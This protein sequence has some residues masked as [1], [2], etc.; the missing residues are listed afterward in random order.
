[1]AI[2]IT[3]KHWR[4]IYTV[5][6]LGMYSLTPLTTYAVTA[7][8]LRGKRYCEIAI[9]EEGLTFA[10]YN[11]LGLN[12][13]PENEWRNITVS[14]I[15]SETG[16]YFVHLNGPRYLVMD[17]IK[18]T[19]LEGQGIKSVRT[20]GGLSMRKG[21]TARISI[22][23]LIINQTSNYK[24]NKVD[25][26]SIFFYD[27]G[28][29]IYELISPSGDVYVMQSYSVQKTPQTQADL[30]NLSSKLTLPKGW[31]YRSGIL[32]KP[33]ALTT[34]DDKAYVIFDDFYNAYQK[35]DKNPLDLD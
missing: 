18:K 33:F 3:T 8:D 21:A 2:T 19:Q 10:V 9:R 27:A 20:F 1:M 35:A 34:S 25:R 31:H 15:R 23:S 28:K 13:C 6:L 12:D 30:P 16:G 17:R 26:N 4:T 22:W 24:E 14:S 5:F 11:T 29:P 7:S 32:K